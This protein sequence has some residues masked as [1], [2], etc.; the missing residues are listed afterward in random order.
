M[1]LRVLGPQ[2]HDAHPAWCRLLRAVFTRADFARW[3]EWGQWDESYRAYTM[4]DGDQ[5][6]ANASLTKMRLLLDGEERRGWQ[7]GAVCVHPERRGGG[8]ARALIEAA[9]ADCGD[10]P[11]WLFGNPQVREFYPRF[12]FAP[13]EEWVFGAEHACDPAATMASRLDPQRPETRA[14]VRRLAALGLPSSARFGVRGH[15]AVINWYLANGL[16]SA[17]LQPQPEV[18]VFCEQQGDCLTIN[19]VLGTLDVNLATLLPQLIDAPIRRLRFGF[20]PERL[21]PT[22]RAIDVDPE[23]DLQVRGLAANGPHK[24]PLLAQT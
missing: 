15:G 17:P 2:S 16:A 13:R 11:V 23:P 1:H 22:A 4:F 3:I 8:L 21:W 6:I 12:G 5:P 20:T 18:L 14:L 10:D 7:F 9:L 19:E 24:F